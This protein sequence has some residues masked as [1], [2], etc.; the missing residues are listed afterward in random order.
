MRVVVEV[1][2]VRRSVRSSQKLVQ[3]NARNF[4]KQLRSSPSNSSSD[5]VIFAMVRNTEAQIRFS[6]FTLDVQVARFSKPSAHAALHA[7]AA[8]DGHQL[9]RWR[10][11]RSRIKWY[12][13]L[14]QCNF[15]K[16][17][18]RS[19]ER[20]TC[21]LS[22]NRT[23]HAPFVIRRSVLIRMQHWTMFGTPYSFRAVLKSLCWVALVDPLK[24]HF[25]DAWKGWRLEPQIR[26]RRC[27]STCSR[28]QHTDDRVENHL[29]EAVESRESIAHPLEET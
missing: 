8:E 3:E 6:V 1:R 23:H 26:R 9:R 28:R 13:G 14:F 7:E 29:A 17:G 24:P 11:T 10:R 5:E 12:F 16:T 18:S 22:V 20:E 4:E 27:W 19:T 2:Q 25:V 15:A 21:G